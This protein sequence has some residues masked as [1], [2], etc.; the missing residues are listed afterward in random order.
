MFP[1][2]Q[3]TAAQYIPLGQFVD[4]VDGATAETGLTIA[5]TDIKLWRGTTLTSKNSGGAT[6]IATGDYYAILDAT[7]T[8]TV[9]PLKITVKMSGAL[10]VQL[11]CYVYEEA[12][13]DLMFAASATGS[14]A[15]LADIQSRLPAALVSGRMDASVGAMAA[16]TLTASALATDAVAEVQ[17]GLATS[18]SIAALNNITAAAVLAAGDV[19]GYSLE[20]ALKLMLAAMAGKVSGAGTTTV[21]IRAVDDSKPR[22]TATVE[23]ATGNRS[24]LTLDATG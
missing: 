22:I 20:N 10:T 17:S 14:P 18:A 8:A 23:T 21:V 5:N 7:D 16:N 15:A 13:Y 6:H 24:A 9:G 4:S 1:L 3:S 19:D 2:R 11:M 12:V